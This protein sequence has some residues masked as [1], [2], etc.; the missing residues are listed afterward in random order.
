MRVQVLD[1]FSQLITAAFG[2]VA[3]LAWNEAIKETI[4]EYLAAGSAMAA[5]YWYAV[6]VTVVAVVASIWVGAALNRAKRA[7]GRRERLERE[8][9]RAV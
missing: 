8:R 7:V 1:K 4:N 5:R 2:F 3:A 9:A 6:V